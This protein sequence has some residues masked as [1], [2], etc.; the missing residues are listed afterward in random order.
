MQNFGQSG[1]KNCFY[2]SPSVNLHQEVFTK[3]HVSSF[4]NTKFSS[5]FSDTPL[6]LQA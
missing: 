2:T 4:K 5:F 1:S 3:L 6:C